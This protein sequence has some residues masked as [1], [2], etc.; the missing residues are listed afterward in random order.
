MPKQCTA[1]A[2]CPMSRRQ[3]QVATPVQATPCRDIKSVSRHRFSC[4]VPKP[5]RP[6][7]VA[8]SSSCRDLNSQQARS[9]RQSHVA[10][11]WR[12]SDVATSFPCRDIPHC[13]PCRDVNMMSRPP[14]LSPMSRRQHDV[15]TSNHLSLISATSRSH[16][17]TSLAATHVATLT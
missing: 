4:P 3:D 12:L 14:A 11:S 16:V 15:A 5:G 6:T 2:A 1:Q 17:A 10:T 8:T 7:Y 9:R 13:R